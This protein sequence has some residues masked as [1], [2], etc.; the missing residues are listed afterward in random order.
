[1]NQDQFTVI[2]VSTIFFQIE[3]QNSI[4]LNNSV[5]YVSIFTEETLLDCRLQY[6]TMTREERDIAILAKIECGIHMGSTTE[7]GKHKTQT[8]RKQTRNKNYFHG[9]RICRT[10]FQYIHGIGEQQLDNISYLCCQNF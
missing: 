10:I 6:E 2:A 1:M 3:I 8:E 9:R 4:Q 7:R 5:P